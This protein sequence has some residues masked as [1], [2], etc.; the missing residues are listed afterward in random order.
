MTQCQFS[1]SDENKHICLQFS[2]KL[3]INSQSP[4]RGKVSIITDPRSSKRQAIDDDGQV[5]NEAVL[6]TTYYPSE[7]PLQTLPQQSLTF[8]CQKGEQE[9]IILHTR[10]LETFGSTEPVMPPTQNIN[11]STKYQLTCRRKKISFTVASR[12][13]AWGA[14]PCG[15]IASP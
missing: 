1:I 3:G 7:L 13:Q 12:T 6:L 14:A 5:N 11:G 8:S 9:S 4:R 15:H 10:M 2:C